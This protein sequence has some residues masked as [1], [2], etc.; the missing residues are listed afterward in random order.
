M[1]V[2]AKAFHE[3]R[4]GSLQIGAPWSWS[5]GTKMTS[6][7]IENREGEGQAGLFSIQF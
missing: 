6:D 1:P 4:Q 2:L 5:D 3:G 7:T